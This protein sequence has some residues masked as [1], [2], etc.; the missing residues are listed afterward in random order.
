MINFYDISV[1]DFVPCPTSFVRGYFCVIVSSSPSGAPS[2]SSATSDLTTVAA[3]GLAE[4]ETWG[5]HI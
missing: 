3:P 2:L 4:W 5:D 1:N